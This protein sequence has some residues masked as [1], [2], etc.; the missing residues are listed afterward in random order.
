MGWGS[1]REAGGIGE[2]SVRSRPRRLRRHLR[3]R[4]H[5]GTTDRP[6]VFRRTPIS[7]SP[8]LPDGQET[9]WLRRPT[10]PPRPFVTSTY[11]SSE[12][13]LRACPATSP[14]RGLPAS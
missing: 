13:R 5:V 9:A 3:R 1:G 7:A 14:F 12:S 10:R 11:H 6:P 4:H 8:A 2:G